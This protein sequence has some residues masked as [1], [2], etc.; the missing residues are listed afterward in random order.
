MKF[1]I[2]ETHVFLAASGNIFTVVQM[3]DGNIS[4]CTNPIDSPISLS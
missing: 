3:F 1:I 2:D 4:S